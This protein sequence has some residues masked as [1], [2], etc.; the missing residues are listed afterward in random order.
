M[1]DFDRIV[2]GL[3]ADGG[4]IVRYDRAGKWY[5]EYPPS[6]ERKRRQVN[7]GEAAAAAVD[8]RAIMGRYGG[9]VFDARVRALQAERAR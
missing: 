5:I 2:H 6:S 1:S 9:K 7:L 3:T 8:G 4:Q